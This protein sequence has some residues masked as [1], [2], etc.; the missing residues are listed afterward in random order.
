MLRLKFRR[1]SV[2]AFVLMST[3]CF[4]GCEKESEDEP[5]NYIEYENETS[6]GNDDEDQGP[7]L[8]W[9]ALTR[10]GEIDLECIESYEGNLYV[11]GDFSFGSLLNNVSFG[12]VSSSGEIEEVNTVNQAKF[13]KV[14]DLEISDNKLMIAGSF[15]HRFNALATLDKDERFEGIH[16]FDDYSSINDIVPYNGGHLLTGYFNAQNLSNNR[17]IEWMKNGQ[18]FGVPDFH[19]VIYECEV[20]NDEI[21]VIDRWF[22]MYVLKGNQWQKLTDLSTDAPDYNKG[23]ASFNGKLYTFGFSYSGSSEFKLYEYENGSWHAVE[24]VGVTH[25]Y[26]DDQNMVDLDLKVI[27]D[28]LY[29]YGENIGVAFADYSLTNVGMYDGTIWEGLGKMRKKVR[30]VTIHNNTLTAAT[31]FGVYELK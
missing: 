9:I 21:Y 28:K 7:I 18:L 17:A 22:E 16:L 2:I 30:D 8:N 5:E 14:R 31:N 24:F 12:R 27:E 10:D 4:V 6:G 15:S 1:T 3:S 29:F 23:L 26:D 20:Y 13:F 19:N 11:G 25:A